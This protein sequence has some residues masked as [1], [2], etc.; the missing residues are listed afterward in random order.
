MRGEKEINSVAF[1]PDGSLVAAGDGA[2]TGYETGTIR[3]YTA[4]TGDPFARLL[5]LGSAVA[6]GVHLSVH[7][8]SFE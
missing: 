6:L 2:G 7:C 3:L 4:A 5:H 1:S 8:V